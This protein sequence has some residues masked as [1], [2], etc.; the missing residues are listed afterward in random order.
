MI[1]ILEQVPTLGEVERS[2]PVETTVFSFIP[3][4]FGERTGGG[5]ALRFTL[6]SVSNSWVGF[7]KLFGGRVGLGS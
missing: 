2:L 1:C 4:V 6:F 5:G 7:T 3:P